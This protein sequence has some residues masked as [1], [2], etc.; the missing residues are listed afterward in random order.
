[1]VEPTILEDLRGK[2][3]GAGTGS[4]KAN[5]GLAS[6]GLAECI[7]A[8][9]VRGRFNDGKGGSG[10]DGGIE[11]ISALLEG[12]ETSLGGE[13][14]GGSDHTTGSIDRI[15]AGGM[16]KSKGIEGEVHR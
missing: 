2:G 3:L 13:G 7:T 5:E 10:G 16:V 9:T 11:G 15:T 12:F 6:P 14:I 4:I 8:D 1:L